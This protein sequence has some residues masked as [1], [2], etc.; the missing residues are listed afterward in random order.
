[1]VQNSGMRIKPGS[2][3]NASQGTPYRRPGAQLAKTPSA[4]TD[5]GPSRHQTDD[6]SVAYPADVEM[7]DAEREEQVLIV[8]ES[9]LRQTQVTAPSRP[10][11]PFN[12]H[13]PSSAGFFAETSDRHR[14]GDSSPSGTLQTATDDF[15][16]YRSYKPPITPSQV[17]R[18]DLEEAESPPQTTRSFWPYPNISS[19]L[20]G[21]WFWGSGGKSRA[22]RENLVKGVLLHPE[23]V[24]N[25][26]RGVNFNAIDDKLA[27]LNDATEHDPALPDGWSK[28]PLQ[29][30]VPITRSK[31]QTFTVSALHHRNIM[32]IIRDT[33][34]N[35]PSARSFCYQPYREFQK[36]TTTQGK[37]E[38]LFGELYTSDA[39]NSEHEK[40]QQL[41]CVD[42]YP[43]A[44]AALMFWSDSTH[45]AQFGQAKLW[46]LYL[47]FG[48]QSKYERGRPT[49]H[50]AHHVAYF[51]SLP[52]NIKDFI[53]TEST[54]SAA[55]PAVLAHCRRELM[56]AAWK[57]LLD[58]EFIFAYEHGTVVQCADGVTRRLFPRIFTYSAD[59]PEKVLLATIRDLGKCPCP[60]C[61]IKKDKIAAL[62]AQSDCEVRTQSQREDTRSRREKVQKAQDLIAAGQGVT[63]TAVENLLADES[64]VPT[65]NA[66][67]TSLYAIGVNLFSFFV[68]DLLHEFDLG[69][70]KSFFT[71]LIRLL[72]AIGTWAVGELD[73]RY[74]QIDPF[75]RETIRKFDAN[76]SE[77]K[78]LAARDFEDLLLSSMPA[79]DG[80]FSSE[81][82]INEIIQDCLFILCYWHALAKLRL[83]TERTLE[84]L[85]K[86]TE[87]LGF[88]LRRFVA[89]VSQKIVAY[90]TPKE[91]A[92]RSRRRAKGKQQP[93]IEKD[94]RKE[95]TFN[96]FTYKLH[97]LGDY[98]ASIRLFGTTESWSTQTGEL[99]HRRV[100]GFW[101]RTNFRD[102]PTQIAATDRRVRYHE[103]VLAKLKGSD[104]KRSSVKGSH[105][106]V[107]PSEVHHR[108]ADR[109]EPLDL[110]SWLKGL[111]HD[112]AT[113][114]FHSQLLDHILARLAG[115]HYEG[116]DTPFTDAD[117]NSV[118]IRNNRLFNHPLLRVN[119]TTYDFR[120]EQ[121]II[122][123]SNKRDIMLLADEDPTEGVIPHPF[124]YAR[125]LGILHADVKDRRVRNS[126]WQ[127]MEF[128]WVRWF[129]RDMDYPAGWRAKRLDR[130][131]YVPDE[132]DAFGFVDPAWVVRGVHLIP[133]FAEGRTEKYIPKASIASDSELLG[134]WEFY[135]VNRF[136]D[137]DMFMRFTGLGPGHVHLFADNPF[138]IDVQANLEHREDEGHSVL[139][140]LVLPAESE[141]ESGDEETD[142]ESDDLGPESEE[143]LILS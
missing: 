44:I 2:S 13:S 39:F 37:D 24:V 139:E 93:V 57:K 67:S 68:P 43:K 91:K 78:K 40:I 58:P 103:R 129:G 20:L 11:R 27:L 16:I 4:S 76:V 25:D 9:T 102:A 41:P 46:P 66:F 124:W 55:R 85:E 52:D 15:G 22:D 131:G 97:A 114:H 63:S 140:A 94:E 138:G 101:K 141:S 142:L 128:L 21:N 132:E 51:P 117:R 71:H 19:F 115:G 77:M 89:Q 73:M 104:S 143:E 75:G 17:S 120:R 1:M 105:E 5:Q 42:S 127:R 112:P 12:D 36:K 26:I 54:T 10:P 28:T 95:K 56:H 118:A 31:P 116:K 61:L 108:I 136:C 14:A 79:F 134:D 80:L 38:R 126:A 60:R 33:F 35:H 83:H 18:S 110:P 122:N 111:P 86:A 123:L 82:D 87:D 30:S 45:L 100:K 72:N 53:S 6:A 125:V 96:M 7:A 113:K 34:R 64:L 92:A 23:F 137:R 32:N 135:H 74:R 88:H 98:V 119:Y 69:V 106:D 3:T 99:E 29:I 65:E 70:W 90:E 133:A 109:G 130:I 107:Q 84:L 50:S 59:Y 121:D 81:S 49:S 62:G 8:P 47:Y 48:N